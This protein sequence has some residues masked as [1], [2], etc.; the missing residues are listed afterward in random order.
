MGTFPQKITEIRSER[1]EKL[2]RWQEPCDYLFCSQ[3]VL[4]SKWIYLTLQWLCVYVWMYVL[5]L[6]VQ[7]QAQI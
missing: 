2:P 5:C 1:N 6:C 4:D 3:E 7:A